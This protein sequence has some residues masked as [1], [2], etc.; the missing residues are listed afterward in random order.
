MQFE[1]LQQNH[2]EL[3]GFEYINLENLSNTENRITWQLQ[4]WRKLGGS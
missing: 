1:V 4:G 3:Y 2:G